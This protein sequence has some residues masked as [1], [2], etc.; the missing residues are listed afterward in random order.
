VPAGASLPDW[1][2][3]PSSL[4]RQAKGKTATPSASTTAA[5]ARLRWLRLP[6]SFPTLLAFMRIALVGTAF[7]MTGA[8]AAVKV[9]TY[10]I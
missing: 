8:A 1:P 4:R 3:N 5:A 9:S 6:F 2:R 7:V 10:R